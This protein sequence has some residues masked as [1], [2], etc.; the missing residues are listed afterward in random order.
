MNFKNWQKITSDLFNELQLGEILS[1]SLSAEDTLFVRMTQARIRQST[2]VIQA[3]AELSL[4]QN[5][6]S[7]KLIVP[8]TFNPET[9]LTTCKDALQQCRVH[10]KHL[11]EDPYIQLPENHGHFHQE[12]S[13]RV[14]RY[15]LVD[16]CLSKVQGTDFVGLLTAG[17]IVRANRNSKG[18]DQWFETST[19]S[20]DFSLYTKN[21][22]AVKGLYGG[23]VWDDQEYENLISKK[24]HFL[25]HLNQSL[26][27][28]EKKKYR[29]YFS[30]SAVATL[31]SGLSWMGFSR[32]SYESGQ[33]AL[34]KLVDGE[35]SLSSLLTLQ[36]NFTSGQMPRFNELGEISDEI[37]SIINQG[38]FQNLLCSSRSAKEYKVPS[39]FAGMG[40]S[41]RSPEIMPGQ[42][43]FDKEMEALDT[44]VYI[45]DLHYLN[46]S[47]IQKGSITGMTRFGCF[48]IEGGQIVAPVKDMRFDESLYHFWGSGLEGFTNKNEIFPKTG[49]YYQ[50][51]LGVVKTPGMLVNDFTFVL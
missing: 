25:E 10:I 8:I 30:P 31:L 2:E 7:M 46:W 39:N 4:Y 48:W 27:A 23:Q 47:N 35:A 33:C 37:L 49:S 1:M 19:F 42:I 22:Q 18:L 16:Q 45:S 50:R 11:P 28:L 13:Q 34:K 6:R 24:L 14:D 40:E 12:A 44:G 20:V 5:N 38:K 41:L 9:D 21:Q 3:F 43:P 51:E 29:A 32:E 36:E 17:E 15:Q 26:M